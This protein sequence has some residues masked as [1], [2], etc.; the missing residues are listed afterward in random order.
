MT[1]A[2]PPRSSKY[3]VDPIYNALIV[4]PLR[5]LGR[6]L[7]LI[8]DNVVDGVVETGGRSTWLGGYTLVNATQTGRLGGYSMFMLLGVATILVVLFLF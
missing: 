3:W 6:V 8:D 1:T 5:V 4:K 7:G 2:W